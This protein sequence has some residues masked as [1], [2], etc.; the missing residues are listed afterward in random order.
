MRYVFKLI[1][2][3]TLNIQNKQLVY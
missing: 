1:F 2:T 3:A